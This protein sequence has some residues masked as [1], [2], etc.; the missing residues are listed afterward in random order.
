M[1]TLK[2]TLVYCEQL[3]NE[4]I[5]ALILNSNISTYDEALITLKK[6]LKDHYDHLHNIEELKKS[7]VAPTPY[8]SVSQPAQPKKFVY[9]SNG[10]ELPPEFQPYGGVKAEED[11]NAI[12]APGT[13]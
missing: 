10:I 2:E 5:D 6:E 1:T 3:I 13:K 4:N 8:Q 9:E 12:Y 11:Y 7:V